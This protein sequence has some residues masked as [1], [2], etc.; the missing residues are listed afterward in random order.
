MTLHNSKGL[1]FKNVF[2]TGLEDGLFPSS[3]S[4]NT[5]SEIEE[6]RRLCYVGLTRGKDRVFLTH[7]RDRTSWGD[8]QS[9]YKYPSMFLDEIPLNTRKEEPRRSGLARARNGPERLTRT[10]RIESITPIQSSYNAIG[11]HMQ[12][13]AKE[14]MVSWR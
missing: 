12:G 9:R 10:D 3:N 4:S 8:D 2:I 5:P 7:A 11:K 13:P 6:E 14:K 1:E